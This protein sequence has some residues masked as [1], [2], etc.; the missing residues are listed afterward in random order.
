MNGRK[1]RSLE[2]HLNLRGYLPQ[3]HG[4]QAGPHDRHCIRRHQQ[5]PQFTRGKVAQGLAPGQGGDA[6]WAQGGGGHGVH[7]DTVADPPSARAGL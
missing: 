4:S 7:P 1:W 6:G 5:Q 2:H 3:H